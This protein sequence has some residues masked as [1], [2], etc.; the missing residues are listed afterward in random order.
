[1]F[2]IV[3]YLQLYFHSACLRFTNTNLTHLSIVHIVHLKNCNFVGKFLSLST[4][5]L[6]RPIFCTQYLLLATKQPLPS[7]ITLNDMLKKKYLN[8]VIEQAKLFT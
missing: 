8:W 4:D 6:T 3:P 1:M 2:W 7:H 5:N